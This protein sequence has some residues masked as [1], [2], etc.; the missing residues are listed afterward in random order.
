MVIDEH[1][2]TGLVAV[3]AL[4]SLVVF[5]VCLLVVIA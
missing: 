3:Y 2:S 1:D 5:I 4:A